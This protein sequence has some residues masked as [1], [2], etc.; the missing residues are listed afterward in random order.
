MDGLVGIIQRHFDEHVSECP[1]R[2][3]T[4]ASV[5]R[6][7]DTVLRMTKTFV[8][9]YHIFDLIFRNQV[10][11]RKRLPPQWD[12]YPSVLPDEEVCHG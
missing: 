4:V 8:M 5:Y 2:P 7:Q 1:F 10:Q 9:I 11:N 6:A 12:V 3:V